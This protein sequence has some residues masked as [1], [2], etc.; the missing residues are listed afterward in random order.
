MWVNWYHAQYLL[1]HPNLFAMT[2]LGSDWEAHF[3]SFLKLL[4]SSGSPLILGQSA[5]E[6]ESRRLL[7]Q[8]FETRT[9]AER[10][11]SFAIGENVSPTT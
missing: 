9:R 7:L 1:D 8:I 6:R 11:G 2:E 4:F 10:R 5:F 3:A